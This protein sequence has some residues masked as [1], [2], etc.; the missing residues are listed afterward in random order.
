MTWQRFNHRTK[1]ARWVFVRIRSQT[2]I[3]H[4]SEHQTALDL[5]GLA[6][7]Q[8]AANDRYQ[9]EAFAPFIA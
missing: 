7:I 9:P 6:T 2:G 4:W 1:H 8:T 3:R 5:A